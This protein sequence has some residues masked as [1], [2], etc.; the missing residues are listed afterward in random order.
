[1]KNVFLLK[2]EGDQELD[3]QFIASQL[4]GA[5]DVEIAKIED[6]GLLY[7]LEERFKQLE[8]WPETHDDAH[9]EDEM[10]TVAALLACKKG[11]CE[12]R[13]KDV[14]IRSELFPGS[15]IEIT[16]KRRM[17]VPVDAVPLD[18]QDTYSEYRN[19]TDIKRMS[20]AAALLM[21]EM[22]KLVRSNEK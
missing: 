20:V 1:M 14:H 18:W 9:D 2:L 6:P 4:C 7:A 13:E 22:S 15:P 19:E 21:A 10:A 12:S 5:F 11:L 3:V 17:K 16:L 8:L